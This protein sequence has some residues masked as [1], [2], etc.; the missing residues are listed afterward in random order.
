MKKLFVLLMS[1]LVSVSG[2]SKN[3]TPSILKVRL[4]D[5]APITVAIDSRHYRKAGAS[6]TIGDLPP[7][8]H[9]L[10]IYRF[11]AYRDGDAGKARLIYSANIKV[12]AGSIVTLVYDMG[13]H[14]ISLGTE[15][16]DGN[17]G[18]EA[19]AEGNN[20]GFNDDTY[21]E[22]RK[23]HTD[24][25]YNNGSLGKSDMNDLESKVEAKPGDLDKAKVLKTTLETRTYNTAQ[26]RSMLG[27]LNFEDTKLDFAKWAYKN[28]S[29][30]S[31]YRDLQSEFSQQESKDQFNAFIG[32]Q[33]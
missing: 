10:R 31:N 9:Y 22:N 6:L 3:H 5:N 29:D 12:P 13:A 28:V 16:L 15:Y 20:G 32:S 24:D 19:Y 25:I 7:G 14:T 2:F 27:W 21:K 26:V 23:P 8:R 4:A 17:T 18:E 1:L 11:Y 30:K 33:K